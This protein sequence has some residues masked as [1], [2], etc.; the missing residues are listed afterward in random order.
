VLS[1]TLTNRGA[2]AIF[3]LACLLWNVPEGIGML[4]QR[5]GARRAAAEVRDR[6]SLVTLIGLQWLG[7]VLAV[8]LGIGMP[9]AAIRWQRT[10]LFGLGVGLLLLGVAVRWYAIWALGKYFTREVAVSEDQLIV[11][12]GPYRWIRH[13]AYSGT[14]L[15]MLGVWLALANWASLVALVI[16]V[17]L[18]HCYRV[19]VEEGALTRV[20]GQPYIEYMGRT[21]RFIPWLW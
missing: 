19:R 21:K 10:A 14:F 2:A 12:R 1:L 18:G 4:T 16:C 6:G 7:L 17:G 9:D 3:V 11:R 20:I 13:P 8:L 5:A 15:T